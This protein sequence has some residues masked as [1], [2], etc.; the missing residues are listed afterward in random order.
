MSL[1]LFKLWLL[2]EKSFKY[3]VKCS[4]CELLCP[5][6]V[7]VGR[8]KK[9]NEFQSC[10]GA[11]NLNKE[12]ISIILQTKDS[13]R[14]LQ[15]RPCFEFSQDVDWKMMAIISLTVRNPG[16]EIFFDSGFSYGNHNLK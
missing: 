4:S 2:S 3:I 9:K 8:C 13:P 1:G 12:H 10:F 16:F 7:H 5:F 15:I 11:G 14:Q 6:P